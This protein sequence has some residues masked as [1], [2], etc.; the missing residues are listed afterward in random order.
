MSE[1]TKTR[2]FSPRRVLFRC[3]VMRLDFGHLEAAAAFASDRHAELVAQCMDDLELLRA[4]Q[5]PFTGQIGL[6]T[7]RRLPW[8]HEQLLRQITTVQKRM[9]EELTRFASQRPL[10][11]HIALERTESHRLIPRLQ[12]GELLML[13]RSGLAGIPDS[14][15]LE[16]MVR[17]SGG[18]VMVFGHRPGPADAITAVVNDPVRDRAVLEIAENL[19]T[20]T[21]HQL[22]VL[23]VGDGEDRQV[24]S[25][26]Y[27][28]RQPPVTILS[29][30]SLSPALLRKLTGRRKQLLVLGVDTVGALGAEPTQDNDLMLVP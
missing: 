28:G 17:Q 14:G 16:D 8:N 21:G 30:E 3:N 7:A 23:V 25:A 4:S 9:R 27:H 10:R 1:E 19:A 15:R 2:P 13:S 24:L 11:W 18:P 22:T 6:T 20:T 26:R 5:L 12:S 29:V